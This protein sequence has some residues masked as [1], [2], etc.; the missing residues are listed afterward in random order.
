MKKIA[1]MLVAMLAVACTATAQGEWK[2]ENVVVDE[3]L[4]Q[5]T[6]HHYVFTADSLSFEFED[7]NKMF[8]ATSKNIQAFMFIFYNCVW[9]VS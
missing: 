9:N 6:G 4:D 1:L 7:F 3:L 8:Y 2:K 5:T